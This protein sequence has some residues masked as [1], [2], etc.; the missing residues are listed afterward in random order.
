M[1]NTY[2]SIILGK[3]HKIPTNNIFT[4]KTAHILSI[5]KEQFIKR[6]ICNTVAS[7]HRISKT[8]LQEKLCKLEKRCTPKTFTKYCDDL[9]REKKIKYDESKK[10][11]QWIPIASKTSEELTDDMK[12][13]TK[14][15][16]ESAIKIEK[17]LKEQ[18]YQ[19][20]TELHWVLNEISKEL[21]HC[22][23]QKTTNTA[24]LLG[25]KIDI[26]EVDY[27]RTISKARKNYPNDLYDDINRYLNRFRHACRDLYRKLAGL[28]DEY[29]ALGKSEKRDDIKK[30]ITGCKS[31]FRSYHKAFKAICRKVDCDTS[32]DELEE[33]CKELRKKYPKN[34][35]SDDLF[36]LLS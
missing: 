7:T 4:G 8:D 27:G 18:P 22:A 24:S 31:S 23:N 30:E 13:M 36:T 15:I 32:S 26:M 17:T 1:Y 11:F 5:S 34:T 12:K 20:Q 28:E 33:I 2:H 14:D 10:Y 6:E 25:Y 19:F 3:R 21:E 35:D 9:V 29:A 16:A